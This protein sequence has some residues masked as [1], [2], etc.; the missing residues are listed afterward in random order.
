MRAVDGAARRRRAQSIWLGVWERNLR[1]Q[2]FYRKC[3]FV[4]VGTQPF[5]LGTEQQVDNVMV[6]A[7][8]TPG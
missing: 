3:G 7:L 5:L 1:A 4:A 2:G 6:R 8:G